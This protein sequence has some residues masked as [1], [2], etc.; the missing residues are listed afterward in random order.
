[1]KPLSEFYSGTLL[2]GR[3]TSQRIALKQL[4]RLD[5]LLLYITQANEII[6]ISHKLSQYLYLL[7]TNNKFDIT[8]IQHILAE[9][10]NCI[11]NHS[12]IE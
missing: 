1:M 2:Q 5:L 9:K 11:I 7:I 10:Q 6:K 8:L 3:H 4:R 12:T